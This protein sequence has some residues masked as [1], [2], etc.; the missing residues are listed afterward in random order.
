MCRLDK[1]LLKTVIYMRHSFKNSFEI[2]KVIHSTQQMNKKLILH[3]K[4]QFKWHLNF[5]GQ[6]AA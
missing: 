2:Q 4:Y 1:E 6:I 5:S 3:I